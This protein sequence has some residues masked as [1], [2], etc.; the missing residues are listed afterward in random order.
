M[1]SCYIYTICY[2]KAVFR[3]KLLL[4]YLNDLLG[5]TYIKHEKEDLFEDNFEHFQMYPLPCLGQS[6]IKRPR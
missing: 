1:Y 5:N 3:G 2:F 6:D 4:L